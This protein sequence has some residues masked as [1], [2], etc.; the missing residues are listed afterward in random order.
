[1]AL[2]DLEAM[3][4]EYQHRV[5]NGAEAEFGWPKSAY[6]V[7]KA[8]INALT[9]ILA[10][11]NPGPLINCCCPG[12][13]DTDMGSVAGSRPPKSPEDGAKIPIRLGFKELGQT[14]G[15][16]WGN[17]SV[18]DCGDGQVQEW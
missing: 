17:L 8:S 9:A 7:S 11:E 14:T 18:A 16:Y 6:S 12:W 15:K 5:Q 13:V 10:R 1:M 4:Q 3:I 2:S